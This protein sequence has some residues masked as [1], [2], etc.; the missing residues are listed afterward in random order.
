MS[1]QEAIKARGDLRKQIKRATDLASRCTL[2]ACDGD[3]PDV[4]RETAEQRANLAMKTAR[5]LESTLDEINEA[6]SERP[7]RS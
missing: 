6:F 4:D 7:S 3:L 5:Q 1:P 2:Q